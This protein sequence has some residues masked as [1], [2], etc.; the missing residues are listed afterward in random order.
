[1]SKT[2]LLFRFI[3]LFLLTCGCGNSEE[4]P[5]A[6]QEQQLEATDL[7]GYQIVKNKNGQVEMKGYYNQ[8]KKEGYWK[9]YDDQDR[10][11]EVS[12]Y[13]Q[14]TLVFI[15]NKT[16]DYVFK[17]TMLSET[18][19]VI[20]MPK[21]WSECQ[22]KERAILCLYKV[23]RHGQ[24]NPNMNC[25]VFNYNGQFKTYI[26]KKAKKIE[27]TYSGTLMEAYE[28]T[29]FSRKNNLFMKFYVENIVFFVFVF[30]KNNYLIELN[31]SCDRTDEI[32]YEDLFKEIIAASEYEN[33]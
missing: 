25:L 32:L 1:M 31:L 28:N 11:V 8:G 14:D 6:S 4:K 29:Y 19:C 13:R 18:Q 16:E 21:N 2:T 20:A 27:N 15:T 3:I 7:N 9:R 26:E 12:F 33:I 10:I 17:K 22:D 23:A 5:I 24:Y 30:Q